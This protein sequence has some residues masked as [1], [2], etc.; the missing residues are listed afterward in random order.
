M[1]G[2]VVNAP[3]RGGGA[4]SGLLLLRSRSLLIKSALL[5]FFIAADMSDGHAQTAG[6]A[7]SLP[8]VTVDQPVSRA[9]QVRP[10]RSQGSVA[11]AGMRSRATRQAAQQSSQPSSSSAFER[12]TD[13]VRGFVPTVS[14]AAMK[15][16]TPILETPQAVSVVSRDQLDARGVNTLVEGLQY[17]AG[18]AVQTGGTDP[19]FE[20]VQIRGFD[21]NGYGNYRDGLREVG[22]PNYFS[23]FRTEPYGL[24]RI[25]VIKG[26]SSVMYGQGA[27][28]G[29]VDSI[30]KRPTDKAFGEV[31]G[32]FGNYDRFQG[33]FD[34]GGPVTKDGSLL[35]RVT[36]V[37]RD[38]DAQIAH[39]SNDVKDNRTYI[40]PSV[41]WKP[42]NDTT[43][44]ILADYTKD[45]T[46]NA[47]PLSVLHVT[48]AGITGV[49]ALPIFLGD[50]SYNRFEQEQE[51]IGY[52]FEHRF[53]NN[54]IFE[55]KAR[56]GHTDLD[57]HYLTFLG[58]PLDTLSS[59]T[60][61]AVR[62]DMSGDTFSTDNHVIA[63]ID[64][65]PVQHTVV[66]GVDY[67]L[68]SL[69]DRTYTATAGV[70]A[71][72]STNPVY[73]QA[74]P[75]P[76]TLYTG[77]ADQKIDQVGVYVQDQIKIQNWILTL[78]GR[79]DLADQNTLSLVTNGVIKN[80]T[81]DTR[82][83]AFTKRGAIAYEF[84]G[85]LVPYYSYSESFLP[86]PGTDRT[87]SPFK[88]TTAQQHEIGVKFQPSRA[89]LVTGAFYD[90]TRQNSL[91]TDPSNSLFQVQLGEVNSRGFEFEALAEL[92]PGL[93]A[94]ATFTSQEVKVTQ[95]STAAE[96][97]KVPTLVPA[98]MASAYL[99]YTFQNGMLANWGFGG[100]VRYNGETFA[101][102]TNTIVNEGYVVFDAGIHYR[103]PKG[104]NLALN[105]KNIGDRVTLACTTSGGCQY[106][107]PRTIT[108][109][110]SYR[111]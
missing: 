17:V 72:S 28:G 10:Q 93:N 90:L 99:D 36:G 107:S 32:L 82:N 73:G 19:R 55:S 61:R 91:T 16:D 71:L 15:S 89:L 38:A 51:R 35:Y 62:V 52:Q 87:G 111:W 53:S 9:R 109:T 48:S 27:P 41:T 103:R 34:V 13:P 108:G 95:S 44:T 75:W 94:V 97:G 11:A 100:G 68:L 60:R 66:S 78:G 1:S 33:A 21:I 31:V 47:F 50:P 88:P 102:N 59:F 3:A 25:D 80:T 104:I 105:V 92:R 58:N 77:S 65:G 42:T 110:M 4:R 6:A 64:T 57:Y 98:N 74:I 49:T 45:L 22:D 86:T 39:F 54:L 24:E 30:S 43:L 2:V 23:L 63:K 101:N 40:A 106:T 69:Q 7:V 46:G 85:G 26:P 20:N 5:L 37:F 29:L 14:S 96:I 67:Q 8:P 18:L 70:P 12:G 76:T 56:Y 79:Y 81:T 84:A 83:T